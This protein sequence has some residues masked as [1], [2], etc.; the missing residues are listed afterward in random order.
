MHPWSA[1]EQLLYKSHFLYFSQ[2]HSSV[3]AVALFMIE[4]AG[5]L[6]IVNKSHSWIHEYEFI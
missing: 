5:L 3:V 6:N 4:C 2:S 1:L